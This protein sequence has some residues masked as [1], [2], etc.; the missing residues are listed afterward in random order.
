M[1]R[2]FRRDKEEMC[3][4]RIDEMGRDAASKRAETKVNFIEQG[5]RLVIERSL[6]C[7]KRA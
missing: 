2:V 5:Y 7:A 4:P 1:E 6:P 3:I